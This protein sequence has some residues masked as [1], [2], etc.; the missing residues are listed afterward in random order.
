MIGPLLLHCVRLSRWFFI[1]CAFA[2]TLSSLSVRAQ[3]S[4]ADD[5]RAQ[6]DLADEAEVLFE[7]G[8]EAQR[9]AEYL[10]ALER[11]LAS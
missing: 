6:L 2:M 7:L 8:V 9:R 11:Y 5:V 10:T 1:A 3:E 4:E